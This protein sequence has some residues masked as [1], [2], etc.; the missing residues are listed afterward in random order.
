MVTDTGKTLRAETIK[1]VNLPEPVQVA[2]NSIGI[3]VT[4]K[5]SRQQRISSIDDRWRIDDEW[6]RSEPVSR[7]YYAVRLVSGQR[8]V[9]YKDLAQSKWYRQTV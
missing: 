9:L 8:I 6:W 5:I 2:E 4:V 1:P 7:F 3:P